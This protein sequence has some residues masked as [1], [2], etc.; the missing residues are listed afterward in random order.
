M[1]AI[2]TVRSPIVM[3]PSARLYRHATGGIT[4]VKSID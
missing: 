4:P 3:V 2:G 1:A